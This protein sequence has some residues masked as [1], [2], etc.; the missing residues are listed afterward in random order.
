MLCACVCVCVCVEKINKSV[1]SL[2]LSPISNQIL[3]TFT[4]WI[5]HPYKAYQKH[6]MDFSKRTACI[7]AFHMCTSSHLNDFHPESDRMQ[8][9]WD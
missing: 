6:S 8:T 3:C 1:K 7:Y 2:I 4:N 9:L 5:Q